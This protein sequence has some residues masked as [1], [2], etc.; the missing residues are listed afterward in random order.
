M[1][2]QFVAAS[3]P[4]L[5]QVPVS[6]SFGALKPSPYSDAQATNA[7]GNYNLRTI[8]RHE[9][10]VRVMANGGVN[11]TV[12]A[13]NEVIREHNG[14]TRK[15][16]L[17]FA[18]REGDKITLPDP[19][20]SNPNEIFESWE[21]IGDVPLQQPNI[22]I[23][24]IQCMY[25]YGL[26]NPLQITVDTLPLGVTPAD[27]NSPADPNQNIL[28]ADFDK[29]ILNAKHAI[30]GGISLQFPIQVGQGNGG[31]T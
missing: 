18:T 21:I 22:Q 5:Q 17:V 28:P 9:T 27:V 31:G 4:S 23:Q 6:F 25:T 24:R 30:P 8:Y 29:R 3:P 11:G 10:G 20:T 2:E 15:H 19:D 26:I 1:A 12:P 13:T 7:Y 16:V 14:I